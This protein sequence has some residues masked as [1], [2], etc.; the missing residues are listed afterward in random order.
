MK[1]QHEVAALAA[2][3]GA[4]PKNSGGNRRYPAAL[5]RTILAARSR[6]VAAGGSTREFAAQLGVHSA[7]LAYWS[8]GKRNA[9]KKSRVRRVVV[10]DE[11]VVAATD[12]TPTV[13]VVVLPGGARIEGLTM[14]QL[15]AIARGGA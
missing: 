3:V 2:E 6:Y 14:Q 7:T 15:I 10:S 9:K 11:P 4:L 12:T 8:E 13:A 5:R 1:K